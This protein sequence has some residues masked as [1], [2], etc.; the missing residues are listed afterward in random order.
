MTD[1]PTTKNMEKQTMKAIR[2]TQIEPAVLTLEEAAE[3][4][5]LPLDIVEREALRG[6]IP[7]RRIQQTWR[8]LRAAIDDW[9]GSHDSRDILLSQAGALADDESLT[10][11]RQRIYAERG[12]LE[13]AE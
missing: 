6:F 5:R 10:D 4:L 3:Y 8:F 11:L 1:L 13:Q 2:L 9:L 12:R 7:G